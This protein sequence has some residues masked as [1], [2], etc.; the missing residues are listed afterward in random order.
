MADTYMTGSWC[1]AWKGNI[2]WAKYHGCHARSSADVVN[3][4]AN[5]PS[6][7]LLR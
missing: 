4:S 1:S 6:G 2:N 3:A 5:T 7:R